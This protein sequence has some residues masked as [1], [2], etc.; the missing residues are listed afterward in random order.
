MLS[1]CPEEAYVSFLGCTGSSQ[2]QR[3][4]LD[5]ATR[6]LES[7]KYLLCLLDMLLVLFVADYVECSQK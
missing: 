1:R 5:V 3:K 7:E 2:G 4:Y 6:C